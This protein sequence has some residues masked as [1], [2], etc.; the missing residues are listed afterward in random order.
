VDLS[1]KCYGGIFVGSLFVG[2][3]LRKHSGYRRFRFS[4]F[5]GLGF[6]VRVWVSDRD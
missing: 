3:R 1:G 5:G 2:W 6:W 4:V